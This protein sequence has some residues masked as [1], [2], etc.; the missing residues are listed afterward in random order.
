VLETG[1]Q[2]MIAYWTWFVRSLIEGQG[3]SQVINGCCHEDHCHHHPLRLGL[4]S[5]LPWTPKE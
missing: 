1:K 4:L 3:D 2:E 5:L